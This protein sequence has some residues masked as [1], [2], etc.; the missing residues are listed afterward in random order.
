VEMNRGI[1]FH[2]GYV[3]I[4]FILL[5]LCVYQCATGKNAIVI[6]ASSGIGRA[7][8][9]LLA[10]DG[11][12]LGLVARRTELLE[13]LR[14]EILA[15]G[16][17]K[18]IDVSEHK[19]ARRKIAEL[20]EEMGGL[21]LMLISVSAYADKETLSTLEIDEKT[22]DVDLKGFWVM[23]DVAARYFEQQNHGHL[24]GISSV[25]GLRG[26]PD[27]PVYSAAKAFVSTYL[28]GMRNYFIKKNIP[29]HVTDIIPGWVDTEW[30]K[31]SEMDHTY[32]VSDLDSA[33]RQIFDAIKTKKK[34]AYIT[35]R[36]A[37]V[38]L[39]IQ[40]LPDCIF[41]ALGGL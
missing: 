23:A 2:V 17:V 5:L 26:Q 18:Q 20:I 1:L 37:F 27:C 14:N 4:L 19:E 33:A 10:K 7:V 16:Y 22:I 32:W 9:K 35:Q 36:W 39:L 24:V 15:K 13:S 34:Y 29:V 25:D 31:P 40:A 11:Y 3:Y 30:F 41:N 21:D 8:A 38:A 12:D 6:G 28:E